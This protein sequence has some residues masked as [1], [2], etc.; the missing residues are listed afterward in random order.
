M[1]ATAVSSADITWAYAQASLDNL[2]TARER[3]D[4]TVH[5]PSEG[6]VEANRNFIRA[7][8]EQ[9]ASAYQERYGIADGEEMLED[10]RPIIEKWANMVDDI[11]SPEALA[12]L[13][14][15]EVY[16]KVDVDKHGF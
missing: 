6:L 4:I 10:F 3:E 9:I 1:Y 12:E 2:E 13:Y 8:L 7:D 16:S 14:W 11:D 15:D 5:A